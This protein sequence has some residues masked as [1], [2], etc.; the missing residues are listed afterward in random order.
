[1]KRNLLVP[2]LAVLLAGCVS[3]AA[4]EIQI[5]SRAA[6]DDPKTCKFA[7]GGESFLGSGVLDV[8]A[9]ALTY[10]LA[11]YVTNNL[12]D[13]QATAPETIT[14]SKAWT[15]VAAKV[16]VNPSDYVNQF[17]ASPPLLAITDENVTPLDG[18]TTP[19][20]GSS[21]QVID[22]VS[23]PLGAKIA[24]ALGTG[25]PRSVVL[26]ITLQGHTADGARLDSGEW[27]F[28]LTVCSGC[29]VAPTCTAS[30]TLVAGSC[31]GAGQDSGGF[32]Q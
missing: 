13:P 5:T 19:V 32:C 16:R 25:A 31:F 4:S 21:V 12:A 30:Q 23:R 29:L 8:G 24:A 2:A 22:A 27:F 10:G 26:G 14:S 1:M 9:G 18:T 15:A 3:S 28:P 6:P 7:A 20:A 11:V 17:G